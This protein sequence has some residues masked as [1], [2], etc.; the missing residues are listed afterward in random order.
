ME[1]MYC[2]NFRKNW[3]K[4][5]DRLQGQLI[6][7][8]KNGILA[9]VP[10]NLVLSECTG[11]WDSR[12]SEGGRWLEQYEKEFPEKAGMIRNILLK[13]MKFEELPIKRGNHGF[14]KYV[15]PAGSAAAGFA[16][17]KAVGAGAIVQAVCTAAP[18]AVAYPVTNN[19]LHTIDDSKK[20]EMI[21]SYLAQLSKYKAGIESILQDM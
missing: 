17:S 4:F 7:Q 15:I 18:A 12:H 2:E 14:L 9:L 13:D 5:M 6:I 20:K 19:M 1:N 11:F 3:D 8:A 21:Q 16:I 10:S